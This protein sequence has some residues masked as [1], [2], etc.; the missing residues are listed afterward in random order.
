[1]STQPTFDPFGTFVHIEDGGSASPVEVTETFW[2]ELMSGERP[3]LNDGWLMA[4]YH[5]TGDS[6]WEVHPSGDEILYLLSGAVD[7]ILQA[8]DSEQVVELQAGAVC[9]VPRGTWHRQVVR[10]AGDLLGIT[11]GKGS[12]HRPVE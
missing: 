2:K 11:F 3:D 5:V 7:V 9:V 10:E 6:M 4:A 8:D 1:M 12:H